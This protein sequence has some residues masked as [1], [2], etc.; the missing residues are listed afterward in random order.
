MVPLLMTVDDLNLFGS[1][2]DVRSILP[3]QNERV[4]H[5]EHFKSSVKMKTR[6][7]EEGMMRKEARREATEILETLFKWSSLC[8]DTHTTPRLHSCHYALTHTPQSPS[9]HLTMSPLKIT[10]AFLTVFENLST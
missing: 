10:I 7:Q 1:L 6:E 4:I 5:A 9:S 3:P 8:R 2:E